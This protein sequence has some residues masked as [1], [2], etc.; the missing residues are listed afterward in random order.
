MISTA[1]ERDSSRTVVACENVVC[2]NKRHAHVHVHQMF[3]LQLVSEARDL[4]MQIL[5]PSLKDL[6]STTLL[7]A[8]KCNATVADHSLC[9][10]G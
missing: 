2:E 10:S 9:F 3:Q 7:L 1:G 5:P 8:F 4:K 6:T